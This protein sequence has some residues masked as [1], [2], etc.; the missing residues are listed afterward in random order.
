MN[1]KFLTMKDAILKFKKIRKYIRARKTS[2]YVKKYYRENRHKNIKYSKNIWNNNFY[3][4]FFFQ[5]LPHSVKSS[6][7]V[8][9]D[10]YGHKIES[11]LND[12][13]TLLYV[14][15]KNMYDRIFR[16]PE[17]IIPKTIFRCYNYIFMDENYEI[18]E[19]I[20]EFINNIDQNIII[21]QADYL[22]GGGE[23]VEKYVLTDGKL[24]NSDKSGN[25][26][27]IVL[28]EKLKGNFIAQEVVRQHPEMGKY[29]P[30]SVNT[31]KIYTYRSVKTNEVSIIMGSIRMGTGSTF[32]DN[33][34]NGG[35]SV[36]LKIDRLANKA[37]LREFG[38]DQWN[39]FFDEHPDTKVKFKDNDI[40]G[41][42]L[43]NVAVKRL[44]NLIPYQRLIGWDFS[45][46]EQGEPVL[47]ELN[48]G[49]GVWGLQATNGRPLFGDFT[50]EIKEY[51][52]K[53]KI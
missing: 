50:A 52:V 15:D 6:F 5:S 14:K 12:I 45:I 28:K 37:I 25:L 35:L 46:N 18:I 41:F 44:A 24:M 10:Y 49:S 21:K 51:I 31:L 1:I 42:S 11:N 17:V 8:P 3:W 40:P 27:A 34:S 23:G 48:T 16:V 36:G 38:L 4:D 2:R 53:N 39:N 29:H 33:V 20:E 30:S 19:N 22:H 7:F 26:D 43:V 47:I 32:L 13:N 9:Q